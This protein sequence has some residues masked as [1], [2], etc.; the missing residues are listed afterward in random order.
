MTHPPDRPSELGAGGDNAIAL[1]I[2]TAA[3]EWAL[4]ILRHALQRG[5]R[6]AKDWQD[7][8][9]I[10]NAVLTAR[11]RHLCDTGVLVQDGEDYLLSP[12]GIGLW[13]LMVTVWAWEA[14]W[15]AGYGA[16]LPAM[17][18][19]GCGEHFT[20]TLVC[21]TCLAPVAPRDVA[22][23]FGP[24][25]SWPR[26]APNATLRRRSSGS[27][28]LGAGF[29]PQS[30]A[31]IG[32]RWSAA[33]LG[34]AFLGAR[35]AVE[36]QRRLGAPATVIADRLRTFRALGVL[37]ATGDPDRSDRSLYRLTDKGRAFFP[38]LMT[39]LDWG[40][41]WFHAPEGPAMLLTH[42]GACHPYE[43][44]L[45]CSACAKPLAGHAIEPVPV[46]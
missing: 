11:L 38:V 32:D 30:R 43:T 4:L 40:E 25:G 29:F 8:L 45:V 12:R 15:A 16:E 6:R 27:T 20:P 42:R 19:A 18:H 28:S 23:E 44:L 22:A 36:F 39:G 26:S 1:T 35:R 2:G 9:P 37:T 21:R 34:A 33:V 17:R 41:R 13:P 7:L 31:L 14:V 3:D 46:D 24:S 5:T 10:T